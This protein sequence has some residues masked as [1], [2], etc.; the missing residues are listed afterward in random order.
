MRTQALTSILFFTLLL[1]I[2]CTEDNDRESKTSDFLPAVENFDFYIEGEIEGK[3]LRYRQIDYDWLNVSNTF[4][5]Q[6]QETWLQAYTDSTNYEGSWRIRFHDLDI[7]SIGLPYRLQDGEG[8]V[9]WYDSR[10]DL[11]IQD[12]PDCQGIDNGCTFSLSPENGKITITK[13]ED[14]VVEGM[15][16]GRAIVV[17][18]GSAPGQLEDLYH[19][20][21]KGAFRIQYRTD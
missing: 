9:R 19:D 1:A 6:E 10:V 15:F 2:A 21:D 4:F 14:Q 5:T 20:I 18:T 13:V 7:E 12:E 8:S 17:R 16:E 11:I 3:L